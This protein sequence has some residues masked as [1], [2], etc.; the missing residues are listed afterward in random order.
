VEAGERRNSRARE[1]ARARRAERRRRA[2]VWALRIV[3]LGVVFFCGLAVGKAVEQGPLPAEGT[4][5]TVDRT[6]VPTTLTPQETV[7]V[8]VSSP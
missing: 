5:Q 3:V 4:S 8:T 7:T 1:R 2:V 6:L